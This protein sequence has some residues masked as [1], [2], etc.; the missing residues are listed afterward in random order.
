MSSIPGVGWQWKVFRI[1]DRDDDAPILDRRAPSVVHHR[2]LS[3][4]VA[5]NCRRGRARTDLFI[6][7]AIG[8][9]EQN[10]LWSISGRFGAMAGVGHCCVD[11]GHG[12]IVVGVGVLVVITT[13][14]V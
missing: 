11:I 1:Q 4:A 10:F 2:L 3:A 7:N 13:C 12:V 6:L 5:V 9:E 14:G 8:D